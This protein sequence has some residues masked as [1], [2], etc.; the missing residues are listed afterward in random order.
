MK[1]GKPKRFFNE[2]GKSTD[3]LKDCDMLERDRDRFLCVEAEAAAVVLSRREEKL[4]LK[5]QK[6]K[7]QTGQTEGTPVNIEN[8]KRK[9]GKWYFF[10]MN[11]S[12]Q[13]TA[14]VRSVEHARVGMS[15]SIRSSV[16]TEHHSRDMS[17][18]LQTSLNMGSRN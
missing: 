2:S 14:K 12:G 6:V 1:G 5:K 13:Y 8:L 9:W 16:W 18:V 4:K 3:E 7:D 11:E 15:V 17:I 10:G